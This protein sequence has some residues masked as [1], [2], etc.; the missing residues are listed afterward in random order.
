MPGDETCSA[1]VDSNDSDVSH[2]S[3]F[4][5]LSVVMPHLI[6]TLLYNK[7]HS[8]VHM[9]QVCAVDDHSSGELKAEISHGRS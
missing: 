1:L 5:F 7:P 9:D 8:V 4:Q 2:Q 3:V 6:H